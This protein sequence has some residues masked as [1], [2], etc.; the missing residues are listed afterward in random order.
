[1]NKTFTNPLVSVI[2]VVYNNVSMIE[3]TICSVI[4]QSYKNIEY[5]IIDG[6]SSDG[7]LE[8]INKY[9]NKIAHFVSE[10][11]HGIYNAM[12]KGIKL[13]SGEIIGIINSDDTYNLRTIELIAD[14]YVADNKCIFYG[15]LKFD[16]ETST[17]GWIPPTMIT[18]KAALSE[19]IIPHPTMFVPREFYLRYGVFDDSLR[20]TADYGL[21]LNFLSH[22]ITFKYVDSNFP[23]TVMCYNGISDKLKNSVIIVKERYRIRKQ[24]V[25]SRFKL[26]KF[27]FG[28]VKNQIVLKSIFNLLRKAGLK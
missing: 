28:D 9:R 23:I 3:K 19:M 2:T 27:T 11:D 18:L 21:V 5:I 22:G 14:N 20:I 1:M 26:L 13:A 8:I 24:H 4:N 7:T 6:G 12:N 10:R 17:K 15:Q 25:K 16:S